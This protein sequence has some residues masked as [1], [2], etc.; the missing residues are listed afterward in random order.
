MFT[1][2]IA[3]VGRV[4]AVEAAEAGLRL[5]VSTD[6]DLAQLQPG[7]SIACNGACLTV[8]DRGADWFL[9]DVSG[10]TVAC[11]T[12]GDWRPGRAVNLECA[13]RV[14]DEL[15]GHI[16]LGHVDG[17]GAL[18]AI[19]PEGD[20]HRLTLQAPADLAPMIAQKGSIAVDGISLTVNEVDGRRFTVNIIPHTWRHTALADSRQGDGV[21]LEVDVLA[22]YTARLMECRVT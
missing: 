13:L 22:R 8:V 16:V 3:D 2:L 20:N 11:T 1:G 14:G 17:V 4:S 9:A 7:A 5:T 19:E 15:G 12:L 18:T 6:L 21:N 10:E